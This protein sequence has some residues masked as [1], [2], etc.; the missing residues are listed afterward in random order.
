MQG[1]DELNRLQAECYE[2]RQL[3]DQNYRRIDELI[4]ERDKL[5]AELEVRNERRCETCRS[6]ETHTVRRLKTGGSPV[7]D[8]DEE[9]HEFYYCPDAYDCAPNGFDGWEAKEA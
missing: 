3:V 7:K 5:Q 8:E 4:N 2:L 1:L 6:R 9:D